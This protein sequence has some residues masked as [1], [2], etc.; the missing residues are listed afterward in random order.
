MF[1]MVGGDQCCKVSMSIANKF[2]TP[3]P[4][5][6]WG[7]YVALRWVF[8]M[9]CD[10]Q[11]RAA[12]HCERRRR[13]AIQSVC[14]R[15]DAPRFERLRRNLLPELL[16]PSAPLC[17]R[18]RSRNDD[19]EQVILYVCKFLYSHCPRRRISSFHHESIHL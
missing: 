12:R 6:G 3:K 18:Y 19:V 11:H 7:I 13:A 10:N 16:I 9:A 5:L 1:T 2:P 17:G 15:E 4:F 8:Y 14:V